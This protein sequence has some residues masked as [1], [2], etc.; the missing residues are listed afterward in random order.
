MEVLLLINRY[1]FI[2]TAIIWGGVSIAFTL[3]FLPLL[4]KKTVA[5][6]RVLIFNFYRSYRIIMYSC[7]ALLVGTLT[8]GNGVEN[9]LSKG[10]FFTPGALISITLFI[11]HIGWTL[12]IFRVMKQNE[13]N[14]LNMTER[15]I[16]KVIGNSYFNIFLI[17][18]TVIIFATMILPI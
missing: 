5:E 6:V 17:L 1:I 9:L 15:D 12:A 4:E 13:Y 8:I 10:I 11:V 2:I 18:S 7:W 3:F 14:P 16:K